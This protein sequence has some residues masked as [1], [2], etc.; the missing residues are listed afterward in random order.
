[1]NTMLS[2]VTPIVPMPPEIIAQLQKIDDFYVCTRFS[3]DT[4]GPPVVSIGDD[5]FFRF[6]NYIFL[7]QP[8]ESLTTEQVKR[9]WLVRIQ[10][11]SERYRWTGGAIRRGGL[12]FNRPR[13][14][15]I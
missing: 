6:M 7:P 3:E 11:L 13:E 9:I 4:I 12:L 1:M 15:F 2:I 14:T 8:P 10:C 5:V